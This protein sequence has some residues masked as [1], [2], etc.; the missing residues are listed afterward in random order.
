MKDNIQIKKFKN[1]KNL[2]E[3]CKK[4]FIKEISLSQNVMIAGGSTYKNFYKKLSKLNNLKK[5][6]FFLSDERL[7]LNKLKRN[8][9][10]IKKIFT[11]KTSNN[12]RPNFFF[13][14]KYYNLKNKKQ[15]LKN[16]KKNFYKMNKKINLA[17]LGVG[18]DG[19]IASLFK[20]NNKI[21]INSEP[22]TL[23]KNKFEKFYRLS[24]SFN[25][26][27][28]IKNIVFVLIGNKKNILLNKVKKNENTTVFSE[29]LR[30]TNSSVKIFYV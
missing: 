21:Y 5:V 29:F 4:I 8:S 15:L 12:S 10:N 25:Y 7:S 26:L 28:K 6:N 14:I 22:F 23:S 1:K 19:H 11:N 3:K 20:N 2:F 24:F 13:D 17:F 16:I 9:Y 27:K 18:D 30:K